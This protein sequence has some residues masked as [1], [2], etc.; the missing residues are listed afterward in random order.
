MIFWVLWI[1]GKTKRQRS[2]RK[3]DR[4]GLKDSLTGFCSWTLL[5]KAAVTVSAI[6]VFTS[7]ARRSSALGGLMI[8]LSSLFPI[9]CQCLSSMSLCIFIFE[10]QSFHFFVFSTRLDLMRGILS[11]ERR[12]FKTRNLFLSCLT[13][14]AKLELLVA[15]KV[16]N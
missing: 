1:L 6:M 12:S 14:T 5:I 8:L 13:G 15:S 7:F 2:E 16:E 4:K 3:K 11:S 9:P 10:F